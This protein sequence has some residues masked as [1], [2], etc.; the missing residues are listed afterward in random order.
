[1][2]PLSITVAVVSLLEAACR[3]KRLFDSIISS[4]RDSPRVLQDALTEVKHVEISVRSLERYLL[5]LGSINPRRAAMIQVDEL[6][7]TL[8]DTL[9]TFCDLEKFLNLLADPKLLGALR[10]AVTW[11]S[12]VTEIDGY[13]V[14]LQR[15]KLSLTLM[16]SIIQWYGAAHFYQTFELKVDLSQ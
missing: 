12:R 10:N 14:K 15:H 7:V 2:D 3:I 8:T 9:L 5:H 1:M 13:L 11:L 6:I 4:T 16:L